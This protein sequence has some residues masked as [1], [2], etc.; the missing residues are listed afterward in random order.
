MVG[1]EGGGVTG[2]VEELLFED[3]P[4]RDPVTDELVQAK[5]EAIIKIA[6]RR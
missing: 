5:L 2:E 3:K 1:V 6:P 4:A